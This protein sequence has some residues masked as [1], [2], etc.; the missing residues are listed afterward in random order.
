[1]WEE[2]V[3]GA[4]GLGAAVWRLNTM[5]VYPGVLAWWPCGTNGDPVVDRSG[6][7]PG[8]SGDVALVA[9]VALYR[10]RLVFPLTCGTTCWLMLPLQ[11]VHPPTSSWP[12]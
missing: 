11:M 2:G 4:I 1:M 6:E 7:R 12:E 10:G 3:V 5:S 9:T 8:R